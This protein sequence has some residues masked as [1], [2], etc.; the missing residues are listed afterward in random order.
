MLSSEDA[1]LLEWQDDGS[2][3]HRNIKI[4]WKKR[5]KQK[6]NIKTAIKVKTNKKKKRP[7]FFN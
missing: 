2:D 3:T 7:G 1:V 4:N 5:K 6:Q